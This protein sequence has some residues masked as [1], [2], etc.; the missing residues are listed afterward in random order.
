MVDICETLRRTV[1]GRSSRCG[2]RRW[3]AP[4]QNRDLEKMKFLYQRLFDLGCE[5]AHHTLHHNPGGQNWATLSPSVQMEDRGLHAVVSR[6]HPGIHQALLAQGRRRG[7]WIPNHP[8][9]PNFT[10]G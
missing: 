8:P 2:W 7:T 6:Q 5:I 10:H 4:Y 3:R 9:D 1:R